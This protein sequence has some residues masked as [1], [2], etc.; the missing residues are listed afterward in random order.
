MDSCIHKR[1]RKGLS[2]GNKALNQKEDILFDHE[3][4][5]KGQKKYLKHV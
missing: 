1:I 3:H 2:F 5:F 4:S